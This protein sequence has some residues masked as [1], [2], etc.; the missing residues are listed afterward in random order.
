MDGIADLRRSVGRADTGY[1]SKV[2]TVIANTPTKA[3]PVLMAE[4]YE[5]AL[6]GMT[7]RTGERDG[8]AGT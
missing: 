3:V 5:L 1:L 4:M 6:G 8:P 7:Y 2:P